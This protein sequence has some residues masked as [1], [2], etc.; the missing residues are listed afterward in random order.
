MLVTAYRD[1]RQVKKQ[2]TK[3]LSGKPISSVQFPKKVIYNFQHANNYLFPVLFI[4]NRIHSTTG[5]SVQH[6]V[7]SCIL[8]KTTGV[9]QEWILFIIVD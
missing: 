2:R 9:A 1:T 7:K 5:F 8:A 4:F 6:E 3:S